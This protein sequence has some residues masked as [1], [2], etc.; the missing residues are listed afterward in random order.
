MTVNPAGSNALVFISYART[1]SE[2]AY[3][4]RADLEASGFST[5][6]D[7]AKLGTEGGQ[8]WLRIIQDAVDSCQAMVV[9]VSPISVQSRYV[10]ME[11]HRAQRQGKLVIPLHYQ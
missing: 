3:R 10:H 5:W 2:F 7:T 1:D 11:Y 8:E 4:L 6:I 9:V